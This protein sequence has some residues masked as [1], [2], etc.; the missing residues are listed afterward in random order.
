MPVYAFNCFEHG[1]FEITQGMND[2]HRAFCPTCKHPADRVYYPVAF[3]HGQKDMPKLGKTRAELFDN[4][5]KEDLGQKEWRVSDEPE[6]KRLRDA[7][8]TPK[9]IF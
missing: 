9:T 2:E 5:A 7:G 8:I 3:K 1:E 6:M 4:L